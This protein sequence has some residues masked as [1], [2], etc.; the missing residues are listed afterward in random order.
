VNRFRPGFDRPWPISD[1]RRPSRPASTWFAIER[2]A[3]V[4]PLEAL[5]VAP[6]TWR[7]GWEYRLD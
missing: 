3:G 4:G 5:L 6:F 1:P 7:P 2:R